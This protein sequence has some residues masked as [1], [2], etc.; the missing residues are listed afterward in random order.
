MKHFY[1]VPYGGH[2]DNP[3]PAYYAA[4][5]HFLEQVDQHRRVPVRLR[6]RGRQLVS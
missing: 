3:P 5:S 6:A 4:L 1:E 2:N